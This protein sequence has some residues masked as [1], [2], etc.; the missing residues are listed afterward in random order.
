MG[1]FFCDM[2]PFETDEP[3]NI[4]KEVFKISLLLGNV[5]IYFIGFQPYSNAVHCTFL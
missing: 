4:D 5:S 3:A 1:L 2:L